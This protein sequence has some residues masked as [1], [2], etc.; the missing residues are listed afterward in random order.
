MARVTRQD[1]QRTFRLDNGLLYWFVE[2][3]VHTIDGSITGGGIGKATEDVLLFPSYIRVADVAETR[4]RMYIGIHTNERSTVADPRNF[5]SANIGVYIWDRRTQVQGT[6]DFYP[7]PGAKEIKSLFTS[8][9]GDVLCITTS[10]SGFSE[11]RGINGN[12]YAVLHTFET[13][14]YPQSRR[15]VSQ[16]DNMTVWLG[17]NGIFYAYGAVTNSEKKQLYKIGTMAG[18]TGAGLVCGPA[19][20]GHEY[21][22]GP[23]LGMFFGWRDTPSGI[24]V[25]KW[26]PNGNGT[27]DSIAQKPGQGDVFTKVYTLPSL[28]TVKYLRLMMAPGVSTG[29]TTIA[30]LKCY[31]NQSSTAAWTKAITLDD[32]H[33]GWKNIEINKNNINFIQ[34]EI[35]YITSITLGDSDFKPMYIELEYADENRINP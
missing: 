2:N 3:H 20:N 11:I 8:S 29:T 9:S 17:A 32:I 33:K 18:Q 31:Y 15:G 1:I 26:Y 30:N 35:E 34:F 6:T 13:N 28:A 19:F 27:I 4:S 23:R 21:S 12:Q 14:G 16:I 10:N 22:S 5:S 25:Q 7:A 24:K